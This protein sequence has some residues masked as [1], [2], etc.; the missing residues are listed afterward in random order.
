[1]IDNNRFDNENA[2]KETVNM[3]NIFEKHG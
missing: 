3:L 2:K 1:M